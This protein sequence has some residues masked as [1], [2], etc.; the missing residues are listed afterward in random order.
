[1]VYIP[2]PAFN[3]LWGDCIPP[4][5][6]K[7][8]LTVPGESPPWSPIVPPTTTKPSELTR[9][10]RTQAF[11][12]I[13]QPATPAQAAAAAGQKVPAKDGLIF[14]FSPLIVLGAAMVGLYFLSSMEGKK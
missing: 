8:L 7:P 14:G 10:R 3:C 12:A 13:M 4:A 9:L 2:P 6:D 5:D 11:T 1:M